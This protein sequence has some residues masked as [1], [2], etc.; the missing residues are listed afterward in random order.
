MKLQQ[1]CQ[2]QNIIFDLSSYPTT[3]SIL[4][5][6]GEGECQYILET[7]TGELEGK[8]KCN[9]VRKWYICSSI[10][11]LIFGFFH[12]I[13]ASFRVQT[14]IWRNWNNP[15]KR[16]FLCWLFPREIQGIKWEN[17]NFLI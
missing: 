1:Q 7:E 13:R 10:I 11:T 3:G 12:D 5:F 2:I 4:F 9:P 8:I 16:L 14:C 15:A 17:G 6:L